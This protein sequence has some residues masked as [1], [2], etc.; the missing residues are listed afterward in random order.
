MGRI[1]PIQAEMYLNNS[2]ANTYGPFLPRPSRT[3]TDGAFAPMSPI[4]PVPV[5]EPPPGGTFP[6][7]RWWQYRTSWNLPTPPGTEGL[8]LASFDQLYTLAN[9]YS[10]ARQC[11]E[12]RKDEIRGLNWEI[13]LTTDAARA[14]RDDTAA[15]RDF[16]ER[17]AQAT[18]FFNHPDPDFW[19]FTSFL[20]ALLE[21]IFVY[22]ALA[23]VFR[24][25]YGAS[26]GMGG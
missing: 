2:Y 4:Q 9:R 20:D 12:L 10:V 1:S 5:D 11:I 26:F 22:D 24:L 13:T 25:K 16:G 3:F 19:C 6:D 17:K 7:P 23:V 8:K 21:E 14:Y 15:M 18:K